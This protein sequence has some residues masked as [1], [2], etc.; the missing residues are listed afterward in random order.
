MALCKLM[1]G[2]LTMLATRL[3]KPVLVASS[4]KA[5]CRGLHDP[6]SDSGGAVS[7]TGRRNV[8]PIANAALRSANRR[9]L[10]LVEWNTRADPQTDEQS[11]C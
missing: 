9:L 8:R 10:V 2:S 5:G 6:A 3:V 1:I 11:A 7:S 4:L